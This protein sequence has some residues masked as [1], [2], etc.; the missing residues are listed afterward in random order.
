MCTTCCHEWITHTNTCRHCSNAGSIPASAP[1][2]VPPLV[3]ASIARCS[4]WNI[5]ITHQPR[6]L[7]RASRILAAFVAI[8]C[9]LCFSSA[10]CV[11]GKRGRV[12]SRGGLKRQEGVQAAIMAVP[13]LQHATTL[14]GVVCPGA[15]L[16]WQIR[17]R[18]VCRRVGVLTS[19]QH[20]TSIKAVFSSHSRS[21]SAM[22]CSRRLLMFC[23]S[24]SSSLSAMML[25]STVQ[26]CSL[27][28]CCGWV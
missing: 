26:C 12:G 7:A 28:K 25:C 24:A 27:A 4:P 21:F 19:E 15:R 3:L 18:H 8:N 14:V 11:F 13:Y 17:L 5:H 20:P 10:S 22:S 6:Y 9:R 2:N 16:P 1:A 23:L